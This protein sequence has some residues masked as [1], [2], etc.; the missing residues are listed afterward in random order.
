MIWQRQLYYVS[1]SIFNFNGYSRIQ[2]IN[3]FLSL[4]NSKLI[5]TLDTLQIPEIR[6]IIMKRFFYFIIF[7]VSSSIQSW[8]RFNL[9]CI[10]SSLHINT[11]KIW[12]TFVHHPLLCLTFLVS[13]GIAATYKICLISSCLMELKEFLYWSTSFSCSESTLFLLLRSKRSMSPLTMP[14]LIIFKATTSTVSS[15]KWFHKLRP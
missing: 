2:L 1:D 9:T 3:R 10:T 4:L 15:N 14:L 6:S 5:L 8:K 13:F 12:I 7:L 11:S